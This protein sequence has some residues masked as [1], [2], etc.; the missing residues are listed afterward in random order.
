MK[1]ILEDFRYSFLNKIP[2]ISPIFHVLGSSKTAITFFAKSCEADF[3]FAT[4]KFH[5]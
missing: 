5:P 4:K 1:R 2:E 3:Y